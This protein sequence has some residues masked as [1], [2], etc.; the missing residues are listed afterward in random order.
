MRYVFTNGSACFS[1]QFWSNGFRISDGY[2]NTAKMMYPKPANAQYFADKLPAGETRTHNIAAK[3]VGTSLLVYIDGTHTFTFSVDKGLEWA[4]GV[5]GGEGYPANANAI[6]E[7]Y[8]SVFG[9]EGSE[10][11][12]GFRCSLMNESGSYINK[13]GF[14]NIILTDKADLI[15]SF[16][17]K[18]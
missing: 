16:N 2:W 5:T 18:F 6:K 4:P 17:G 14:T 11:A 15:S 7:L 8:A 10:I 1:I 12:I 3:R 13:T 9:T